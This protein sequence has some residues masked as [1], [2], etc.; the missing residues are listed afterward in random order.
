VEGQLIGLRCRQRLLR[1]LGRDCHEAGTESR[2]LRHGRLIGP[3]LD[4]AVRAP[5]T[6]IEG[7]HNRAVSAQIG[8]RDEVAPHIGQPDVRGNGSYPSG[9]FES[10]VR[11]KL[12][13]LG[14]VEG[15]TSRWSRAQK[16]LLEPLKL[17]FE[18]H[19]ANTLLVG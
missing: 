11:S 3:Q 10:E 15:R 19:D 14:L 2:H 9:R 8:K 12:L 17:L 5:T 6:S 1:K 7:N 13:N 16:L 18:P 4:I